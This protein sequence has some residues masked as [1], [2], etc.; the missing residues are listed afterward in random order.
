M[1]NVW[2]LPPA[3]ARRTLAW[4]LKSDEF[5]PE[6]AWLLHAPM[7]TAALEAL[8]SASLAPTEADHAE[9]CAIFTQEARSRDSTR[10]GDAERYRS[11]VYFDDDGYANTSLEQAKLQ[12]EAQREKILQQQLDELDRSSAN[13]AIFETDDGCAAASSTQAFAA[14]ASKKS[15]TPFAVAAAA[16][17]T[18]AAR[19]RVM[20]S[21]RSAFAAACAR[22]QGPVPDDSDAERDD[23][24]L[25]CYAAAAAAASAA[26]DPGTSL[27]DA[28]DA[29]D[30]PRRKRCRF[31]DDEAQ[32]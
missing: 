1:D 10:D 17:A 28:S 29:D 3:S 5:I 11:A 16:S 8:W 30:A 6:A 31:V 22:K 21:G 19:S 27:S 7:S 13:A 9:V 26:A 2:P 25:P 23:F 4:M 20:S 14:A 15:A 24:N 12:A 32:G 18:R